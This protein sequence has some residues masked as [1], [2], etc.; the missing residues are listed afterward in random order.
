MNLLCCWQVFDLLALRMILTPQHAVKNHP[1]MCVTLASALELIEGVR[2][3]PTSFAFFNLKSEEHKGQ[4]MALFRNSVKGGQKLS[5]ENIWG[6]TIQV[7]N[8]KGGICLRAL[9]RIFL[10]SSL[11]PTLSRGEMVR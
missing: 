8:S 1:S 9:C 3:K 6:V 10:V 11:D 2:E 4:C 5:I 7:I